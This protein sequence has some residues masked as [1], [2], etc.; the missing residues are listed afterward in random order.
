[1]KF[2]FNPEKKPHNNF[3]KALP[4]HELYNN[5]YYSIFNIANIDEPDLFASVITYSNGLKKNIEEHSV[6]LEEAITKAKKYI[7]NPEA[8]NTNDIQENPFA[9]SS[10]I[11]IIVGGYECSIFKLNDDNYEY[12]FHVPKFLD[13]NND[14]V[15]GNTVVEYD[16][17]LSQSELI[18]E[19]EDIVKLY[20]SLVISRN[21]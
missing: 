9:K 7:D 19:C 3:E 13:K 4:N 11:R 1:M 2:S 8:N 16:K 18:S 12:V 10:K 17:E 15:Y 21:K 14:T 5:A 6:S 20:M